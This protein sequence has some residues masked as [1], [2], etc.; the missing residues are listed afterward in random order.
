[1]SLFMATQAFAWGEREQN[2]L[3]GFGAG[4]LVSHIAEM[5]N[6]R[7]VGTTYTYARPRDVV[8]VQPKSNSKH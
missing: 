8:Y 1:A 7:R 3:L 4:V 2:I 6:N 5:H